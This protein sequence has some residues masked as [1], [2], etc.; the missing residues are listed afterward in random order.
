MEDSDGDTPH[1]DAASLQIGKTHDDKRGRLEATGL[2]QGCGLLGGAVL[3]GCVKP[4][5]LASRL[6]AV[7]NASNAARSA[8]LMRGKSPASIFGPQG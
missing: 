2:A 6:E 7:S 8:S 1:L 5:R 4:K 3:L